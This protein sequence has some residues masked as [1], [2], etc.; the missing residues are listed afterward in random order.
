M[1]STL[2]SGVCSTVVWPPT[3]CSLPVVLLKI[4]GVHEGKASSPP[5]DTGGGENTKA[6]PLSVLYFL[7]SSISTR[8]RSGSHG[9]QNSNAVAVGEAWG[10]TG[11][12]IATV[13]S[14]GKTD[15]VDVL[16]D[17]KLHDSQR[18][19]FKSFQIVSLIRFST[20]Y[21]SY[22]KITKKE[23]IKAYFCAY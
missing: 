7:C 10:K 14:P 22:R 18:Q 8:T 1:H 5:A 20:F 12:V 16:L 21:K 4:F 23:M 2:R 13:V 15:F 11:G 3:A 19:N 6:P 17:L 9:A